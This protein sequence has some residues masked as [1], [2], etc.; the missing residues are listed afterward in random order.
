MSEDRWLSNIDPELEQAWHPVGYADTFTD[1]PTRV[2]LLGK[3][4]AVAR[5][6]ERLVALADECPHRLA[7][8]SAGKVEGE[9]FVCGYHGWRFDLTGRC[10]HIPVLGSNSL[11]RRS[12]VPAAWGVT[13]RYGLAWL[14]PRKPL[15]PLPEIPE[16][17]DETYAHTRT[18][19]WDW[20][21]SAG[22]M[23]DNFLD[24]SHFASLHTG[25]LPNFAGIFTGEGT[26][27]RIGQWTLRQRFTDPKIVMTYHFDAPHTVQIRLDDPVADTHTKLVFLHQP[28]NA[29]I[30]R[31]FE[32]IIGDDIADGRRSP[33]AAISF[34]M[35]VN[36]EDK[37]MLEQLARKALPLDLKRELH[38][39][40]D[41]LTVEQRRLLAA[42][43]ECANAQPIV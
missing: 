28:V 35:A 6:G 32:L 30:T 43:V 40:A 11:P 37:V 17:S 7:P 24:I 21:A 26:V 18:E 8:L 31:M 33:A 5:V 16:M 20:N 13:E 22:Q 25:T 12:A 2:E 42:F 27:D 9:E 19:P 41:R 1:R 3:F 10:V 15:A 14:A 4:W 38:T 34:E 36:G 39:K 29:D 23:C